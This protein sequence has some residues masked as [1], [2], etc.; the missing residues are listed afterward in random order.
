MAVRLLAAVTDRDWFD[1]L[2]DR[3]HLQEVNFWSPSGAPFKSLHEGE[4]FL[5]KLHAPRNYIVGGG[6]FFRADTLPCSLAWEAFGDA[7]GAASLVQMRERVAKYRRADRGDRSDFTIGCRILTQPFFWPEERWIPAPESFERAYGPHKGYSTDDPEGRRLWDAVQTTV[8]A[9]LFYGVVDSRERYG[10][11]MLIRPRLGQ[12]GFRIL[13]TDSYR[14]RCA[15]TGERTLP[16][17]DAAHIRPFADGGAH[18]A[19]NGILLRRDIHSLFDAGYVTVTPAMRFEVSGRIREEFENGR[20]YYGLHGREIELPDDLIRR[21][22][23]AA[24]RWHNEAVF[25][26]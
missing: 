11:P 16:A 1:Y 5:F 19:S 4:L 12:G 15:V 8:E 13:V 7:N 26:G 14:R 25:R 21:P 2:R 20:D 24:L 6:V 10:E 9:P 3:P 18:E 17:L 23:P 22:E